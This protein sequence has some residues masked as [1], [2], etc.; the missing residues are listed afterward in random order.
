MTGTEVY[1]KS[2]SLVLKEDN[3]RRRSLK[4]VQAVRH[5]SLVVYVKLSR[6]PYV[7]AI[8]KLL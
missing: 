4:G 6:L 8:A 7:L 2:S 3:A 1:F 5:A